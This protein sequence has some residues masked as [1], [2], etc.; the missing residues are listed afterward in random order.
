MRCEK[1]LDA[2]LTAGAPTW[3]AEGWQSSSWSSRAAL[4]SRSACTFSVGSSRACPSTGGH[5]RP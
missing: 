4:A 5:A 1:A 2:A 3:P